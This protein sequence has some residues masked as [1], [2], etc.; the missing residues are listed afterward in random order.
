MSI[1]QNL[2]LCTTYNQK[3]DRLAS[4]MQMIADMMA[5]LHE[6]HIALSKDFYKDYNA[7]CFDC[8]HEHEKNADVE[9]CA[10]C[11]SKNLGWSFPRK[12]V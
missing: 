4:I 9:E 1:Q 10:K 3:I 12:K 2:A 6:S 5:K 11:K 8:K 7:V